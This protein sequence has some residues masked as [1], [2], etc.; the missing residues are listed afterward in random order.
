MRKNIDSMFGFSIMAVDGELGKVKDF[1]FDDES[2]TIRY[3]VVQTGSWLLGRKVL[4]SFASVKKIN[5]E[6]SNFLVDLTCEQ[7]RN[8][9]DIDTEKPVYRQ[10]E[11]ELHKH[12]LLPPY[13]INAP[14]IICGIDN[15]PAFE[16]FETEDDEDDYGSIEDNQHLRSAKQIIGYLIHA[17]DGEIG[18]VKDFIVDLENGFIA[19]VLV[20]TRNL[21]AGRKIAL[22]TEKILHIEWSDME[23]YVNVSRG[24]I[25][26]SP[27][28]DLAKDL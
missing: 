27:E 21:L 10:H 2:W 18:H 26:E 11:L 28:F 5:C 17:S 20:D 8:S 14:G 23:I 15:Y 24:F 1:Y 19:F 22:S 4:I 6:L 9:P 16:E 13:W 25:I 12:Y 3:I 7:V